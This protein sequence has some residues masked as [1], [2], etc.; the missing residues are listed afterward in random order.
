LNSTVRDTFLSDGNELQ[1]VPMG[2]SLRQC[3]N[4]QVII[5]TTRLSIRALTPVEAEAIVA[6][7]R[8]GQSWASDFPTTGDVRIAAGA[9]VGDMAFATD[10]MPWGVF[11]IDETSSGHSVGGVGFKSAPNERGEVEIGYGIC[12]SFQGRGVATEAV[13]ALCDFA[14]QGAQFVLAETDSENVASQRVLEKS[15]FQSVNEIDG[16]IRWRKEIVH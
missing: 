6:G 1:R 7:V 12:H 2:D 13:V 16:L 15:G 8:T 10:T 4:D 9:L 5:T 11:V 14:R 3:Q